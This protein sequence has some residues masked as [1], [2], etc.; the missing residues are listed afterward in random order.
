MI[1]LFWCRESLSFLL[2]REDWIALDWHLDALNIL[3]YACDLDIDNI[4]M[5]IE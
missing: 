2:A 3:N 1:W 5:S 4:D